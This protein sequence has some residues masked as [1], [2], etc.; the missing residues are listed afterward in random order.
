MERAASPRV[1]G[2]FEFC[3]PSPGDQPIR[4]IS[5]LV[6]RFAAIIK[7]TEILIGE[8]RSVLSVLRPLQRGPLIVVNE[9]RLRLLRQH[10]LDGRIHEADS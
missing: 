10:R 5:K 6:T 8:N 1:A 7:S 9:P 2:E 4:W 3:R